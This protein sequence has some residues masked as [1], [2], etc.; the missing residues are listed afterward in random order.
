[1][2]GI[3]GISGFWAA[4]AGSVRKPAI[5]I[6]AMAD[7]EFDDLEASD[8]NGFNLVYVGSL[9]RRD[10]PSSMVD[11]LRL[12]IQRGCRCRLIILGT[13]S[14]FRET[15]SVL[16]QLMTDPL[17]R[18]NVEVTGWVQRPRLR[19]IYRDAGAFILLRENGWE[20]RACFPTRLPEFLESG[21][22]VITSASCEAEAHLQHRR[23]AWLLP[24]SNRPEDLADAICYLATHREAAAGMGRA[25]R[26]VAKTQFCFRYHGRRLKAFL[27]EL[28]AKNRLPRES[29][30]DGN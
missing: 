7:G 27:D 15:L 11:G 30:I 28:C 24:E 22:P 10:L 2:A 23:N 1:M 6:P 8:S 12:A 3:V 19:E 20:S 13:P 4:Y 17:L 26:E 18:E 21:R 9:F 14:P 29:G 25:G 16:R 5:L